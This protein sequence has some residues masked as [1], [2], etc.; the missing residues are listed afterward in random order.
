MRSKY[1]YWVYEV[2][3]AIIYIPFETFLL[4]A[5]EKQCFHLDHLRNSRK[6]LHAFPLH[7]QC[8]N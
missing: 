3:A 5:G 4:T 2:E 6:R 8:E 1:R 7:D